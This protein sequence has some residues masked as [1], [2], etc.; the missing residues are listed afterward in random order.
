MLF[1]QMQLAVCAYIATRW[2]R[3]PPA[4]PSLHAAPP[5]GSGDIAVSSGRLPPEADRHGGGR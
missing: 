5:A 2:S 4:T 1:H 3:R